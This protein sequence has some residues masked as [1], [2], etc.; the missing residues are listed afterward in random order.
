MWRPN[1][2]QG[3]HTEEIDIAIVLGSGGKDDG[4]TGRSLAAQPLVAGV[5][6]GHPLSA[7]NAVKLTDLASEVL[8][9]AS[10]DLFPAW[11]RYQRQALS[12]AGVA[13]P[14]VTLSGPDLE[15]ARWADHYPRVDWI[16]L[17]PSLAAAHDLT[18]TVP[19]Q[20]RFLVPFTLLWRD[21]GT[22]A[23][24]AG[25]FITTA[26]AADLPAAVAPGPQVKPVGVGLGKRRAMVG[27][28]NRECISQSIMERN[29]ASD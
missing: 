11:A 1:L 9:I 25:R 4:L 27:V 19:V 3:L 15:A 22:A 6:P 28:A 13:P 5:R 26:L 16:L 14:T 7:L 17:L 20:P 10:D 23:P 18:V 21:D 24:I 2:I 12:A 8:G 29:V